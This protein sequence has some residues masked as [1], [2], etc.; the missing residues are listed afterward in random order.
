MGPGAGAGV[1]RGE[2]GEDDPAFRYAYRAHGE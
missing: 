1:N 2:K